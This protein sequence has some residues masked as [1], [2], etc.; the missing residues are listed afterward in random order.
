MTATE[1]SP[2]QTAPSAPIGT[3]VLLAIAGIFYVWLMIGLTGP[4]G[5]SGEALIGRPSRNCL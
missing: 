3:F 1:S 4:Q 2:P 5:G